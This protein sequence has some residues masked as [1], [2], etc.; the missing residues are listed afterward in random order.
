MKFREFPPYLREEVKEEA[1]T[2]NVEGFSRFLE[3]ASLA[4]AQV[5]DFL[6]LLWE[7]KVIPR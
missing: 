7:G 4:N 5:I 1:L 3:V 6:D 2:R